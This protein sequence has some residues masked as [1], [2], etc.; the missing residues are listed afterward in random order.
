MTDEEIEKVF[1]FIGDDKVFGIDGFNVFFKD[2]LG[3]YKGGCI[4]SC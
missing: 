2:G 1:F 4:I 3:C